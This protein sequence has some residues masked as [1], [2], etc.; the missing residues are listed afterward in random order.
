MYVRAPQAARRK[1][2]AVRRAPQAAV[3]DGH[4]VL[5]AAALKRAQRVVSVYVL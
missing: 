4:V 5:R 1:A 2:R 3:K